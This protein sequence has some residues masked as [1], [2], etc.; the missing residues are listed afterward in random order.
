MY[1]RHS[2]QVVISAADGYAK[3]DTLLKD[4]LDKLIRFNEYEKLFQ[5]SKLRS[6]D[7]IHDA[8]TKFYI[9]VI[10]LTLVTVKHYGRGVIST[11]FR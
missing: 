6:L 7:L 9:D 4:T 11:W 5:S 3:I 1:S 10:E 8:L 2:S